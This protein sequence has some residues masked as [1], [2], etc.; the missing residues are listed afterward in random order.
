M[1]P[2]YLWCNSGG[3]RSRTRKEQLVSSVLGHD[4]RHV[5]CPLR[6]RVGIEFPEGQDPVNLIRE[7]CLM[8]GFR[9]PEE[10]RQSLADRLPTQPMVA[11]E[12]AGTPEVAVEG[13]TDLEALVVESLIL[14]LCT[15]SLYDPERPVIWTRAS[16]TRRLELFDLGGFYA[17]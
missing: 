13:P 17:T 3:P 11:V 15:A 8:A 1:N 9:S 16:L 10:A 12:W 4:G 14:G 2:D 5:R 6:R 7:R